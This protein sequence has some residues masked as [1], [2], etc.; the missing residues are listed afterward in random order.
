MPIRT[1]YIVMEVLEDLS[2]FERTQLIKIVE[3]SL[4][5]AGIG[6]YNLKME[7]EKQ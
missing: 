6:I 5:L 7:R 2:E 1:Y 4:R 3:R